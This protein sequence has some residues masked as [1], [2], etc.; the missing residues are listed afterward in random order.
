MSN[1]SLNP[2]WDSH[3]QLLL[4]SGTHSCC[5]AAS[6]VCSGACTVVRTRTF[7]SAKASGP[8]YVLPLP[9]HH[10]MVNTQSSV[11]DNSDHAENVLVVKCHASNALGASVCSASSTWLGSG[12]VVCRCWL[13][14]WHLLCHQPGYLGSGWLH[15]SLCNQPGNEELQVTVVHT[16][17]WLTC[18]ILTFI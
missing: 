4:S 15:R 14:F 8:V 11:H 2:V 16:L 9:R 13:H 1:T 18:D 17:L 7:V 10:S 6:S 12:H 3:T 5:K